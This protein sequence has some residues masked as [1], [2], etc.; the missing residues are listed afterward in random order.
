[1]CQSGP[2]IPVTPPPPAA[3]SRREETALALRRPAQ[4]RERQTLAARLG[5]QQLRA[6]L[7]NTPR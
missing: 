4:Q 7:L 2:T 5:V 3:P 6:G 1:M